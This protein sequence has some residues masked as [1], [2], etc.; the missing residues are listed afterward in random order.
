MLIGL[1]HLQGYMPSPSVAMGMETKQ[2]LENES[3]GCS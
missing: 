1:N 2:S 3:S